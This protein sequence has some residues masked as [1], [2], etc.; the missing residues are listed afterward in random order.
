ME[1]GDRMTFSSADRER[2]HQIELKSREEITLGAR[3]GKEYWTADLI[4][5]DS[6]GNERRREIHLVKRELPNYAPEVLNG[7]S[8]SDYFIEVWQEMKKAGLPVP[9]T[10]VKLND[11]EILETNFTWDGSQIYGKESKYA[12]FPDSPRD[13]VFIDIDIDAV[14][15]QAREIADIAEQNNIKL[16]HDH[17][18]DLL[19]HPDGTW[20][21]ITRDIKNA[22]IGRSP[23]ESVKD[24][25]T[26]WISYF[27][28]NLDASQKR[29]FKKSHPF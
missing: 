7:K 26:L 29:M 24:K 16:S 9:P 3:K 28:E 27:R 13:S 11:N 17:A 19:V 23:G 20:N 21:V 8:K 22:R 2:S 6:Q 15:K 5:E 12:E 14:I 4:T 1:T 10:I 18:F 25:H